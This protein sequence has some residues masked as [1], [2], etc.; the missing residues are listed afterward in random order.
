MALG[1]AGLQSLSA[2]PGVQCRGSMQYA[3]SSV[4]CAVGSVQCAKCIQCGAAAQLP[5]AAPWE[6]FCAAGQCREEGG[7]QGAGRK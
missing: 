7:E 2:G 5:R 4:K 3:V 1:A 6:K